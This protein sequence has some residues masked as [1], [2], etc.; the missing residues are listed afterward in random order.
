MSW[1]KEEDTSPQLR[2]ANNT[3]TE[4]APE[5]E[6]RPHPTTNCERSIDRHDSATFEA[7]ISLSTISDEEQPGIVFSTAWDPAVNLCIFLVV[8][9]GSTEEDNALAVATNDKMTKQ[10]IVS[11]PSIP[12]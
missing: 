8:G 9:L 3:A 4:L 2:V 12:V 7:A 10:V 5:P 11:D 6:R 1:C